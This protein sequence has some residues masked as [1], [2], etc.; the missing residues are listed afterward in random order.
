[1]KDLITTMTKYI[2]ILIAFAFILSGCATESRVARIEPLPRPTEEGI[3][4]RVLKGQT[5]WRIAKSYNVELSRIAQANRLRDPSKIDAGQMLYIPGA[6]KDIRVAT[7]VVTTAVSKTGFIWPV[8]GRIASYFGQKR[9]NVIND[10][11]DI[12]SKEGATVAASKGGVVSFCDD[13]VRG[14]GKTIIIDHGDG[15]S[16]VYAYHSQNLV[17][18]GDKVR[19]GEVIAEV[20][21]SPRSDKYSLHFE[22]RKEE[23]PKNPFYYLP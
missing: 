5:L 16:T 19:K 3:Y 11:I 15:Y 22:I 8:R 18:A 6:K 4:H 1:M 17:K 10:G 23:R 2:T 21:K 7:D 12:L 9:H 13:K 20:G 14:F